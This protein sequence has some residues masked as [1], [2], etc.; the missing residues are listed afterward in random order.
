M[1]KKNFVKWNSS[2]FCI[3]IILTNIHVIIWSHLVCSIIVYSI[4]WILFYLNIPPKTMVY[5]VYLFLHFSLLHYLKLLKL[6]YLNMNIKLCLFPQTTWQR[7]VRPLDR[8]RH[9][10]LH[11]RDLGRDNHRRSTQ[12]LHPHRA[13][14][15]QNIRII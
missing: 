5:F 13:V 14:G 7:N 2:N 3:I 12:K 1:L 6:W 15:P 10:H 4:P 11:Y 8:S 9:Q